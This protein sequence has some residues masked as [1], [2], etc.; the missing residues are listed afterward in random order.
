[1]SETEPV[2]EY[3]QIEAQVIDDGRDPGRGGHKKMWVQFRAVVGGGD[4]RFI[5][6]R[7]EKMPMPNMLGAGAYA[8]QKSNLG[9][10]NMHQ[11]FLQ[12]LQ[13]D[14]WELLQQGGSEWWQQRLRRPAV[15]KQSLSQ[16][17]AAFFTPN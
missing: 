14:G 3:C 5:A 12:S 16:K 13:D 7:S 2:W 15:A 1:M 11:I 8:P 9:H 17:I 4:G 10:T 6:A